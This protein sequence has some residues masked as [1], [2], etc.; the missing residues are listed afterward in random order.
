MLFIGSFFWPCLL[1]HIR[2]PP[3][4]SLILLSL[5][6]LWIYLVTGEERGEGWR[7]RT[8]DELRICSKTHFRPWRKR[9]WAFSSSWWRTVQRWAG[10]LN[11]FPIQPSHVACPLP[12]HLS[13]TLGL[14]RCLSIFPGYA[15][16]PAAPQECFYN[17]SSNEN[18]TIS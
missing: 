10:I 4:T 17:R 13:R 14:A 9:G 7:K 3:W 8:G 6:H 11:F 16:Q 5:I 2:K 15:C 18:S 1:S 12:Q